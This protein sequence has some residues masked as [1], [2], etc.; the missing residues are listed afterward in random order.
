MPDLDDLRTLRKRYIG[1][2]PL[3]AAA[4]ERWKGRFTGLH[5]YD[6]TGD[7]LL[8][9]VLPTATWTEIGIPWIDRAILGSSRFENAK[10]Y[11]W[12]QSTW[13]LGGFAPE[14]DFFLQSRALASKRGWQI[15][16]LRSGA[17][18]AVCTKYTTSEQLL[19]DSPEWRKFEAWI[20]CL[21]H[22]FLYDSLAL[23]AAFPLGLSDRFEAALGHLLRLMVYWP[24]GKYPEISLPDEDVPG[25]LR[26][27]LANKSET[28]ASLV[29]RLVTCT[30][31]ERSCLETLL[32]IR[33][34]KE[35]VDLYGSVCG[36]GPKFEEQR[37]YL[38][39]ASKSMMFHFLAGHE[40]GH[41]L[42]DNRKEI[43][44]AAKVYEWVDTD[45]LKDK[46][47]P[48]RTVDECC[49]DIYGALNCTTQAARFDVPVTLAVS[50]ADWI[51]LFAATR[52]EVRADEEAVYWQ[53]LKNRRLSVYRQWRNWA[54]DSENFAAM[55]SEDIFHLYHPALP[56]IRAKLDIIYKINAFLTGGDDPPRRLLSWIY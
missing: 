22:D 13:E 16:M 44:N 52:A 28:A 34:T 33:S 18:K 43:A 20:I 48:P 31:S 17:L 54:S 41:Y 6:A 30:D 4:A 1:A 27:C 26:N 46:P 56:H 19:C 9:G 45:V 24:K 5:L 37:S 15:I 32:Q 35:F 12:F 8:R 25:Y 38:L 55:R 49:S 11:T 53:M 14:I 40:L 42:T 10:I 3:S 51:W 36:T 39:Q 2:E 50:A 7:V 23:F 21:D 29:D 47:R